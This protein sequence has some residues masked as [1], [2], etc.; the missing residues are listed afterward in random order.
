MKN[1]TIKSAFLA[2]FISVLGNSI[3]NA[4]VGIGTV[5]PSGTLDI[6]STNDG[7]L[8][9]RIALSATNV[10]TVLTPTVSELVYNTFTSALG[11][12]QVAPGYYYWN[13]TLWVPFSTGNLSGWSLTGNT[14]T[15]PVTNFIGT[16]DAVDLVTKTNNAERMRITAAGNVGLGITN[17]TGRLHL[18]EPTGTTLSSTAG[19]LV[20]E[21]GNVGGQ[22]SILFPSA[23]NKG[24][25][26]GYIKYS[27]DG[28]GNGSTTE[29]SLLEI[30]VQNDV[31][32]STFQD[33]I[34][35]MSSGNLGIGTTAPVAKLDIA[36]AVTTTN[37]IVNAT[38]SINDYLQFNV[39]NTSTGIQAQSGYSATANNGT[40]TTGFAW[41]GINNSAFNFPTAYN[42]GVANDVSYIGSGQDMHIANA[43]NTR[44][45]IFSTG[46]ATT[47]FFNERMRIQSNGFVGIGNSPITKLDLTGIKSSG[48]GVGTGGA[49]DAAT[50]TIIPAGNNGTSRFNDW[51]S[52]WGGGLSTYDIVGASTF[53]SAY[54][55]R[56]DRKL[57]RD[58]QSIDDKL[59]ANF[60][61]L[62]PVT[63]YMKE[64]ITETKGLHYG[65]IAQEVRELFPSIVTQ[66]SDPNGIIGMNYQALIA[67]TIYAVQNQVKEIEILTQITKQ[68]NIEIKDL[69]S[70]LSYFENELK[71]L[72]ELLK[73]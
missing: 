2:L 57:K 39:Q 51:P 56:S 66:T 63:Y 55:T 73:K 69:E 6:T 17:P 42:I 48:A 70:K 26:Y 35:L 16:I 4:Q 65:F 43:N 23:I 1:F 60:M 14:G 15:S 28:S 46:R 54:I 67:P 27:D 10:A 47:P 8:I 45:I 29:N 64:E 40:A 44:S 32:G 7:L 13:G 58:I 21:H 19:T 50:Q 22:S 25:D 9:P 11:P 68:Q 20:L 49:N 37:S 53:F 31:P 18:Y 61:Q 72:K 62:R 59:L 52:G 38:G 33:D 3:C 36:A 34:A 5:T 41:M 71:T 24:S 12:N 30:G